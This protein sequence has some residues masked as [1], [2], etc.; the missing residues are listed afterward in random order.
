MIHD[1]HNT[2]NKLCGNSVRPNGACDGYQAHIEEIY[3]DGFQHIPPLP[4]VPPPPFN[5]ETP[6]AS[7][8]TEPS[9]KVHNF[10]KNNMDQFTQK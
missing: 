8:R 4:P 7:L 5:Y 6:N 1:P 10:I 3:V 2:I 9:P